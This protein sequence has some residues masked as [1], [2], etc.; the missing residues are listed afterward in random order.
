M[1][2]N[3]L[4]GHILMKMSASTCALQCVARCC[5]RC[6]HTEVALI[7][8]GSI[9]RRLRHSDFCNVLSRHYNQTLAVADGR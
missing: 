5:F 4:A 9:F 8:K 7:P 3:P 1:T 2:S 6:I